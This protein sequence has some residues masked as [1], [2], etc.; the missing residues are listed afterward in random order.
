MLFIAGNVGEL[1]GLLVSLWQDKH[2]FRRMG[3]MTRRI[4]EERFSPEAH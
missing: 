2:S 4:Y 3:R 1:S